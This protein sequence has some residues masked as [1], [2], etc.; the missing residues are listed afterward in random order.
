MPGASAMT[1][2]GPRLLNVGCGHRFHRDWINLDIKPCDPR[3]MK[4]DVTCG[5]PFPDRHFDA[6]YHSHVV[7]HIRRLDV[8]A[9]LRECYRVLRPRGI[10]RIVTPDL[11]RLCELYLARLRTAAAG[12]A[13]AVA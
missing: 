7:E 13:G 4:W 5:L 6:V 9:F 2:C 11:E 10:M 8:A 1:A 12:D 3:V